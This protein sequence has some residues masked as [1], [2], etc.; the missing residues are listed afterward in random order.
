MKKTLVAALLAWLTSIA[1]AALPPTTARIIQPFDADWLFLKSD[2]S[3][4]E[5]PAFADSAW[6]KLN[7]PHDWS[8]EGPFAQ[9]NPSTGLGAWLPGGIGWYRR[10]PARFCRVRRHHGQQRCL[11]QRV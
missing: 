7:L 3:G 2:A 9:S 1:S 11:D 10:R 5:Q 8:I 6:R 4:A